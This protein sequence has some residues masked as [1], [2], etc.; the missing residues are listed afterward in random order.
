M[1]KG[2]QSTST[3]AYGYSHVLKKELST[4]LRESGVN[5]AKFRSGLCSRTLTTQLP[6][7]DGKAYPHNVAGTRAVSDL[8]VPIYLRAGTVKCNNELKRRLFSSERRN[9]SVARA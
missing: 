7:V 8:G 3:D 6:C 5:K 4:R 9:P 2:V 1:P